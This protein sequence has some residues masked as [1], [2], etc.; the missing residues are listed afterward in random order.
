MQAGKGVATFCKYANKVN[1][2][3][4]PVA[5]AIDTVRVGVS[6]YKDNSN[7]TT[8]NTVETVASVVGGWG[9]GF[10]GDYI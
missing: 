7:G 8:R 9:G 5:I 4:V 2:V 10:G 6:V 1:K 3:V